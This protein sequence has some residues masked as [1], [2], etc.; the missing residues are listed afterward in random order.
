MHEY[1][2]MEEV[3]KSLLAKLEDPA[4]DTEGAE[5]EVVLK[6]GAL[7]IHSA[8]ATRQAFE[9]LVKGTKLDKS[10]L[11]LIVE[12]LILSC[13]GCGFQGSLPEGAVDPHEHLPL[14]PCPQCGAISPVTGSR[15][16]E[17]IELV[18]D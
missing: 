4:V 12:P 6:V 14:A 11:N 2:L 3:V 17:S 9:V 18:L 15:G 13:A 16:V 1:G 5:M 8:A 10:R 7:A